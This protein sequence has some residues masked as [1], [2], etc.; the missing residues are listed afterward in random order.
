MSPYFIDADGW[1]V[2]QAVGHRLHLEEPPMVGTAEKLEQYGLHSSN[3][4]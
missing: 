2:A 3:G 1:Q 4:K